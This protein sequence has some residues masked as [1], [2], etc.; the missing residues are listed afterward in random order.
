MSE[1]R[2]QFS[3]IVQ[4]Q[5][6]VYTRDEFPLVSDFL[7]SYYEGQE[8]QGGPIDLAQNI[9]EYI[10]IDNLT[11]LTGQVGLRT[12]I[13]LNDETI[14]VDMVDY[15]AGTD[16]FPKS[17]GLLKIDNE[18]ITYTG[19][20]T[21]AFTGC[22]RGFCGITSY[23]EQTN[24]DILVFNSSTSEGHIA[25]S[26]VDNLSS[27]FLNEF[28][29]KTKN[30]LL[31]GLEN[32][33]LSSNLNENVFI[34][35]AKDFYLSKGTDRSFEIL[36]KALYE[37]DVRIVKPRDYLFTPSN[38]NYR[39]NNDLVVEAVEGDPTE[40]ENSTLFQDKYSDITEK[41]YAPV[42]QVEPIKV[43]AGKTFY[44]LSFDAGYNRDV[45]V[46]GSVYGTFVVHD[47]TRVIGGVSLGSTSFDVD[48]TVGFPESGELKVVYSDATSGIVSYTSKSINQFF[49][50]SNIIADIPDASDVGI[51]TYT[52]GYS[53]VD[54]TEVIKVNITSVLNSL[55]YPDDTFNFSINETAK[56][57]TLGDNDTSFKAKDWFYNIAPI[58]KVK[59]LEVIDPSDNTY[60]VTFDIDHSFRIGDKADLIDNANNVKPT[61]TVIDVD[62]ARQITI[63]GQGL[64]DLTYQFTIRRNILKTQSTTFPEASLYSTNVQNVYTS[65]GKY[66]VASS[67]IP[68]YNSQPLNLEPQTVTFSGTFVGE[69]IQLQTSG[70][71]GF[72]TGDAVYYYPQRVSESYYD[73]NGLLSSREVI[74][75][76]LFSSDVGVIEDSSIT[77]NEGL[78]FVKRVNSLIIKIAKSRTNLSDSNFIKFDTEI[79]VS[80]NKF[81]PY[82]F[83]LKTLQSQNIFREIDLP[84]NDGNYYKTTPGFTGILINGVEVLNYKAHDSIHYGKINSIELISG[85]SAYDVINPP[86]LNIIDN[87]GTGATGSVAVSGSVKEIR[88]IDPGF[89]YEE[90]PEVNILGGNGSGAKA[91]VNTK[92]ITHKVNFDALPGGNVNTT[93]NIIGFGTYHKFRNAERLI[94]KSN[95]QKAVSGL[96]TDSEYYA[97]IVNNS[98]IT[99]H[100]TRQDA[101]V[102]INTLSLTDF[103]VG[104]Q[105]LE[106]YDK[107]MVIEAINIISSGSG[108]SN[109]KKTI[110]P[111]GINTSIDTLTLE[112]HAYNSGEIVKYTAAGTAVGGL[113]SGSNYYV[114]KVSDNKFKLSSIGSN[115]DQKTFFYDTKQYVDLTS[116]GIG[117]HIFNYEDISVTVS[118]KIGI[119]T[120]GFDANPDEIFG[121]KIQPIV[122]GSITSINLSDQGNNYGDSEIIN[123][124][125]EPNVN[126][127]AGQNA[128]LQAVVNNGQIT[129]VL[130][131]NTGSNYNSPPDINIAGSG[132][133]AVLTPIIENNKIKEIKIIEGGI[134]Y[135]IDNTTISIS[136]P[137]NGSQF[138]A[139]IQEWR[140]NLFERYLKQF[141][142]DDG[143]IAHEFTTGK[144]LQFSHLYAPRKL[145]ESV[146]GR[147]QSGDVL[148]GKPDLQLS[149]G[150]EIQSTDHSPIIGWAY[151][152]NPIYGPYGYI[153]KSGGAI[154][155]M[156]SGY[157]LEMKDG[158]PSTGLY[159]EG[160]FVEDYVYKKVEDDAVLDEN[161]GRFCFTP[162]F[163][164]GTYAYFAAIN[165]GP[166]DSAENFDG[167]KRPVFPYLIGDGYHST[168]N[169]FNYNV[170]SNQKD[171]NLDKS[172]WLRNTQPYNLIETKE[173]EYKYAYIPNDLKQTVDITSV[174]PGKIE[175]VGISSSGDLYR[176]G[177]SIEF[178]VSN[179]SRDQMAGFGAD[180]EVSEVLGKRVTSIGAASTTI[181][182][183]E[184]YPSGN[185]FYGEWDVIADNPHNFKEN[186]IVV[187]SGLS[188]TS[189]QIEG[190]YNAGITTDAFA[191]TGIGSTTV[192]VDTAAV[193]GFVTFFNIGGNLKNIKPNDILE[194]DDEKV[195][196]LNVD[197]LFSRVRVVRAQNGTTG[198]AH[199]VTSIIKQDPRVVK[200]DAGIKTTFIAKRNTELYFNP[201]ESVAQGTASGV[202]IGSTLVFN[203][204]GVGLTELFVPTKSIYIRN[205]DLE[206]GDELTYST[207]SGNGLSVRNDGGG[208]S[209]L[210]NGQKLY[211]AKISDSL[212]GI[213]TVRV[214]LG[215]TGI[216][217]GIASAFR[218][219]TTL[220]FTGIG[221]GVKHSLKTN[222]KPITG[223]I[224]RNKVNVS[225]AD[226]HGLISGNVVDININPG[227]TT[228][229]V[230][231]YNDFNRRLIVDPQ[232]FAAAS[233]NTVTN[234]INIEDHRFVT[235]DKVICNVNT[236]SSSFINNGI[237]YIVKIDN[238]NFKLSTS[239]YNSKLLNPFTVGI[240]TADAGSFA[241]VNPHIDL[242]KDSTVEFDVSDP[243]LGYVS[244]GSEYA[245]FEFNFYT[246]ENFTDLWEKTKDSKVFEVIKTGKIGV[247]ADAKV[248]LTV[249]KNIPQNLFYKL[250]P[251]FENSLPLV[252][253]EIVVDDEVVSGSQVETFESK[254]NGKH[255]IVV[256][257][258]ATNTFAYTLGVYPE[259]TTYSTL[260]STIN[261]STNSKIAYGPVSN[262]Q[263]R[264][265]GQ[266]YYSLPGINTITS[267]FGSNAVIS[268]GSSSIG[269]IKKTKIQNIGYNFPSDTTLRPTVALPQ[270]MKMN[271]L[272]SIGSIGITSVGRGYAVA[273]TLLVFD[274]ETKKQVKDIDLQYTLGESQVKILKNTTGISPVTPIII[275]TGNSNGVGISTVGF[276]T[277]TKDVTLTLSVGF[278]TE[279]SFP[280]AVNDKV[281]IENISIG[282]GSTG[283]GYNSAEYNYKLF[284][285]TAVDSNLGGI[286]IVTYSLSNELSGA[287]YPGLYNPYNSAAARIIPQKYFP[288]FNVN[289]SSNEYMVGETVTSKAK[290]GYDISGIVETWDVKNEVLV[291]SGTSGFGEGEIIKGE[292]SNTQGIA[293]SISSYKSNLN[294]DAFSKVENGWQTDS[295]IL[296]LSQQR[297]QDNDYYQNFSYALRSAVSFSVWEDVVSTLNHTL[298]YKKFSDYQLNSVADDSGSMIVG[299]TTETTE[300]NPVQDLVGYGNL[301]CVND[302][303]LVKENSLIIPSGVV[304]DEIIFSSRIL[305]DYEESIGN[306][307]LTIDDMSGSFNSH[308][309]STPFSVVETFS[310][311]EHR[312]QKYICY[313]QD[314]RFYSQRQL[315]IV[316]LIHD[317][318]FGY[319]QQYGRVESVY[320]LGSFDFMIT[321]S[322]GQ[323]LFY[324]TRSKV[325]DYNVTALSYNLDDNLLGIG[326]TAVGTALIDSHSVSVPKA[327][328]STTIVSIA[329]TY[330]SAKILVEITADSEETSL[331]D[332]F[333]MIELNVVHDGTEVELLDYAEMT[334]TL[335][336]ANIPGFGTYSAYIDGSNF[337]V[338]FHPDSVG[339]GTTVLVNALVVAQSNES[340]TSESAIDLKHA[341]LES[342]STNIAASGSPT[343]HVVGDYSDDYDAAY[344]VI[345]ISDTSNGEYGIA[346]LLVVDDYDKND[347]T[348]ETYDT[349]EYAVVTSSG[350]QS[351]SGL[352]TFYTGISTNNVVAGGGAVGVA[353]TTQLIF[354]PLPS[355]ATN[356]KVFMNAFRYQ[357]DAHTNINFNNSS[358]QV[359]SSDYTGTDR[360]IKR[361]FN[362]THNQN[363]IFDRSFDGAD[364]TIVNLT[365]DTI[366]LPNHFFVSGEKIKYVHAGAG[367]TQA[368]SI[369]S[370]DGF[371]G[372]GTTTKLPGDLFAIKV[373][374]NMI[375]VTDSARKA[376]LS[377][378]ES[379][380]LTA[381]G[382]GLS[383][384]FVS[385]SPNAKVLLCL[386][387]IV[388]SPI[389]ATAVTT[390]LAKQAYTTD[391][392]IEVTGITSIFGG[393]LL[394]MGEEIV[395]I[396][397]IGVGNTNTLRV[398]RQWMGTNLAG[399]S[400]SSLVTKVNGNYNIV[401]NQLNFVEAPYGKIP[402]SSTTNAPDDRDW[403]GISTS[404]SFQG[405]T[406]MRSGVPNTIND[407]YYKNL[408]FD[409]ISSKFNGINKDFDLK[410]NGSNITGIATENAVI[411]VNDVFQGPILNYN[412]N[413]NLGIT[414]IQFTGTASSTTDANITQ[415]PLGGVILS[416]GSTE[417]TGYQPLVAAGGTAVVSVGG[418]ILSIGLGNTGSGY[419]SGV[420]TVGV[421][422]QQRDV[423]A[424]DVTSIGT[425]S[426]TNGHITGVAVTNWN[427]FYKPRDIQDVTYNNT[428]GITTITTATPHGLTLGDEVKLS[429][430]AFTC[431][432]DNAVERDISYVSYNHNNGTMTVTTATP[433]GLYAGK[434]VILTGIAM[435]CDLTA[436]ISTDLHIYPRNRDRIYDT[437][438]SIIGDGTNS[439]VTNA[440]YSPVTGIM[441]CTVANHGLSN[442]DKIKLA[443]NSLSF[444]CAKDDNATVHTY[445][446]A[447]DPIASQWVAISNKTTNTFRIQVLSVTPSTNTTAHTFVGSTTNGITLNDGKISV[448][449]GAAKAFDQY[450][451]TFVGVSTDAVVSGGNY[452]HHFI[453]TADKAVIS[454][455]DYNHS[456]VNATTGGVTVG[457]GTTTP[458]NAIYDA[459]TGDMVLTIPGHG[460]IVGA[461]VSFAINAITFTCSMDGNATNHSYPRATDPIIGMGSTII[462]SNTV[463]TI[464]VNVGASKTVTHDVTDAS[465][466][467]A[468]GSLVLTSP[469]HG[470]KSGV[471][472]RIPDN[473]LTFT[474]DMDGNSTKH[475]Y[476]RSTDPVSNTAISIASTTSNTLTVNVGTSTQV[477]YN[478]TAADY[479]AS[480]GIM[481]MTVGSHNLTTGSSIK[482]AK[483]SLTFSCTKDN[484]ATLHKYPR[485]GD[486]YYNGVTV[487]GVNSPTKF[488]VN[489]GV[490]TVPTYYKSGG[491]VQGVIVAPR[492]SDPSAEGTN[493]LGIINNNTFTVNSGVSTS[494]HFYA[495]GGT[496]EKPLDVIFDEPLSYTNI[497]LNY[498][499]DSVSGVGSDAIIDVVVGQGSSITD[500]SIQNTGY[501]YGIGEILTLPIG[502]ATGIPTTSSYKEF[503]LTIDEIF[504]D[505]F[506]GWS[507][508]TLQAL[509]TPQDEFDA[510]TRTFQLKLNNEIISIR[511]AKGSKIDVQ[512]V[513]LVF[514]NDILQVPGKGYTFE[515]GSIIT[516]TEPPKAGDTCKII[517]YKGS[518]GIDVKS[519]D[520]I[521]TVKIGDDLQISYDSSI[522]QKSWQ[523]EDERSV[524]RVDSTDI[525]T[526]NP[527]FGPGNTEDENLVRPVNWCRQTEDMIINELQI[528]KDRDLYEPNI[529]PSATILKSVGIGSTTVY[530]ENV[531]PFFDPKNENPD[532]TIRATVQ[533]KITLIDQDLKVG[534]VVSASI[535]GG[536]VSSITVSNGGN[537]YTS[538]PSVSV[539]TPVGLGSTAI[540]TATVLGGSV[541]GVTVSYGGTGYTSAPQVLID[542]PTLIS[543]TNDVL[544]YNGDSGT[545]VGFG[546]TVVSNIDKLIFDFY[547]PTDSY[548]RNSNI[549]GTAITVSG[550]SVGDYFVINNSNVGFAQT[551]IVSRSI[552]NQIVGTGISFFDNVYQVDS[553]S[554]VSVANTDIGITTVGTALTSVARVQARISGIST[555]NF[556]SSSIYFDSTNYTFDNQNS[557]LGGGANTGAGYTGGF[558]NRPYLGNFSWG[559]IELQGRSELNAYPFYGNGGV[560]GINTSSLVTRTTRLKVKN[561][562]A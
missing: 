124:N 245:A 414:S 91:S 447:T 196:V 234:V 440:V 112:N 274:G 56:I 3:N 34:K 229:I 103:G 243:S 210:Q 161:N 279:N 367:S 275:P 442:G 425:A 50:C 299:L 6:P 248:S 201:I 411:L 65:G 255:S 1:K 467:P 170:Y 310:L 282:I 512:D 363:N 322:E 202:G 213:A 169:K 505:E 362:L 306:R 284:T 443:P 51:N 13:T 273:P 323:L 37:E 518:G 266:S 67:S 394:R 504:T 511:S 283:K 409:D 280:F 107:K 326:T 543:E 227:V 138:R 372:V 59:E 71:H 452:T 119:S 287:E 554:I 200:I 450:T 375:K 376:L 182:G 21:T 534:G 418:T 391:D 16:G 38:A 399:H 44:K 26:K 198:A 445:P 544:S 288:T 295:G 28:L 5:L 224:T 277:T 126:L 160:F 130:I 381:V 4:N 476:P 292:S 500:F 159:P 163:P 113:N 552:S 531:R 538:T 478:V 390:T 312:A 217:V 469:N 249:N 539:Q 244:Q 300:V 499:S 115:D 25:G 517:F 10:K 157:S 489:V 321:G 176:V 22:I 139:L 402:L 424:T 177:D 434:D 530:V 179:T 348:G 502:G 486:P 339:I 320:D 491:K 444:T 369:A 27:L 337:K 269:R 492:P 420:Q 548:F 253:K 515:G 408:V 8:Y 366:E 205:H 428:T 132:T 377:V 75:S 23:K 208:T 456:F 494:E 185:G 559:R 206:T 141:T 422:I 528:G 522:G 271:S 380:D 289:L 84:S 155:Q 209:S 507:V 319:I 173:V 301:N 370:T 215:S 305:Q 404:S 553:V 55:D 258:G 298:G 407:T 419:R 561:Y 437:S 29:L 549:V 365:K 204:P 415:L 423:V 503:Q 46:D 17:Y 190:V 88:I 455:G 373:D 40:L 461:A 542:P 341:R 557:D 9:D 63:K 53:N 524:L 148:Y 459:S 100:I 76:S 386:D 260:T 480:S 171:Y 462:T 191:M 335:N 240:T 364:S 426:I 520:I 232:T 42:T 384:R 361:A 78:Y 483:E 345:Q 70:D 535:S 331:Y 560:I 259:K 532:P 338:D 264:N 137:G 435:T 66:L 228:S 242:Y 392:L 412:L 470:L 562:D 309:R 92:L 471:S 183:V 385:T 352:G 83:K 105:T 432:Y 347:G 108:Y 207:N 488:D 501:G 371:V 241:S 453:G 493:V 329:N 484:N 267:E 389:V 410:S 290:E 181:T 61:S 104:R 57:K 192:S 536:S 77:A 125:R 294:L 222:Y 325:N 396:E 523:A 133:G 487:A 540:A 430:I 199:S 121:A 454:G 304:S 122:R 441:T 397:S 180:I 353:A 166:A 90:T 344:F 175:K 188:T 521:E 308:P 12:D 261:Y 359:R 464:T 479:D 174:T 151:D 324:P 152:G 368:I 86:N 378:P 184:L 466:N 330:R 99:L 463:N 527:Y 231:K 2:I 43:G 172:S 158:R 405:R 85:G 457:V 316:D 143:F 497:P 382:I 236:T 153:T 332:E 101:I 93:T 187:I 468:T 150:T 387:N 247:S 239:Y 296:N 111:V 342:R 251:I 327:D 73:S 235:G 533:D 24:P 398:R 262:F 156:R 60:L 87:V 123:F 110:D 47:K 509:D 149:N 293:S 147:N 328:A 54:Q 106:S 109:R 477:S 350:G 165:D 102:G 136:V 427:A 41:A 230:V 317:G 555:L 193:T 481:T 286:G 197:E 238:N 448:N 354:T 558:I 134:G 472:I 401:E 212:I 36:F 485:S 216:F 413:E 346:E 525:V 546:T 20:T 336:N 257:V 314:K 30:Q 95:G 281:L 551:S 529:F 246:D 516:F 74:K 252:K 265:G 233:V 383:H 178:G 416:V 421:S 79:I 340:T 117:T 128:Q 313:I 429:G 214:G 97:S 388:Q 32:R 498:S 490:A 343:P 114:T 291:V 439:T 94:Y 194:V 547:I 315:M 64:L 186:E 433:H 69:E 14:E 374:D 545:V 263:I 506:T 297:L 15:P 358:I 495:R 219:S 379:V 168:P 118:G 39:I 333:E 127:S 268:V 98:S 146:F 514:V 189:S 272:A 218:S 334:T 129:E 131:Q 417:G 49:G 250:D 278:S 496:V 203:S 307:V 254:F 220:A 7:K 357:D 360:D 475:T 474:C 513:I 446:R 226:S 18:I 403:T 35:Q 270:V 52:Y 96:T 80:D 438:V 221:T 400:T 237:Y 451:H 395:K 355:V 72:Y 162:E 81:T 89:D 31:P 311:S 256:A 465:Y 519:R 45:R 195:K 473:A 62:G 393:D 537:G 116:V 508:G 225:T 11:N 285:L 211:A 431:I 223:D 302:F 510:D 356:V 142:G 82:K 482:I 120:V 318:S 541:T 349:N 135:N 164:K 556:S 351:I 276:N 303:D 144:G 19:I 33:S 140:I 145:R 58:F 458:T 460:A 167:Y 436:G 406:F 550:V 449:V 526:T 48:S 154:S 68:T